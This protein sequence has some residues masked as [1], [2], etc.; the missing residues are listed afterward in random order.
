M[1]RKTDI[2]PKLPL[3]RILRIEGATR[4]S[5]KSMTQ[6]AL[7]LKAY[8]QEIAHKAVTYSKHAERRTVL[9]EDIDFAI[10]QGERK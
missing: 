4:V 7:A 3:A 8:G 1:T 5:E 2:I 6:F 9:K 10:K